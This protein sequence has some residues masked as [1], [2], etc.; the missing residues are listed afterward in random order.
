MIE[1]DPK[2]DVFDF[3]FKHYNFLAIFP[4][5]DPDRSTKENRVCRFCGESKPANSFGNAHAIPESLGNKT[6]LTPDECEDCNLSF[7]EDIETEFGKWSKIDR[8]FFRIRGKKRVPILAGGRLEDPWRVEYND[9]TG[10]HIKQTEDGP[11][12]DIDEEKK[13]LRLEFKPDMYRP[14]AV[15]KAF[16]KIGL[17]LMPVEEL[18]NF[19]EA[20]AWLRERDHTKSLV[21]KFPVI[22]TFQLG[23]MQNHPIILLRKTAVMDVPYAFLVLTYGNKMFQ[24]Y[25]P[26]PKQDSGIYD[27][28]VTIPVLPTLP[29]PAVYGKARVR[30]LDLCKQ[31]LGEDEKVVI[32]FSQDYLAHLKDLPD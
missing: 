11:G 23:P 28:G 13:Q 14:V 1:P 18:S 22:E 7:G 17:S 26:S 25:L 3:Y 24:V 27:R 6:L 5:P 9:S 32:N 31:E 15:L 4:D 2:S 20:L 16:V 29:N 10:F 8:T 12:I 19:S 30:E 21:K